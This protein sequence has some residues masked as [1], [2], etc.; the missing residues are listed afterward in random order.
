MYESKEYRKSSNKQ[1]SVLEAFVEGDLGLCSALRQSKGKGFCNFRTEVKQ[2][3]KD[4]LLFQQGTFSIVGESRALH[5]ADAGRRFLSATQV[6]G[7]SMQ[8]N[9][10][11]Q[12]KS[13]PNLCQSLLQILSK[14]SSTMYRWLP[15][16]SSTHLIRR[17]RLLEEC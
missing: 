17:H 7:K 6:L 10:H 5:E 13:N 3:V 12:V 2:E 8:R 9:R 4:Y 1:P 16:F 15:S 14:V 11:P